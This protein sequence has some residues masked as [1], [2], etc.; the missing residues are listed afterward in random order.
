MGV[1]LAMIKVVK[2][3]F[4]F[5]EAHRG[6][7]NAVG[8][9]LVHAFDVRFFVD[10]LKCVQHKMLEASLDNLKILLVLNNQ[11][12]KYKSKCLPLL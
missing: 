4:K 5:A 12:L 11:R 10:L 1:V 3:L 8:D 6:F 2:L 9:F 7:S